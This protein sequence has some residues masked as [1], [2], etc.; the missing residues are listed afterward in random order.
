MFLDYILDSMSSDNKIIKITV[1]ET[2]GEFT[3]GKVSDEETIKAIREKIEE[4]EM[5]SNFDYGDGNYFDASSF[6][7]FFGVYG[8]HIPG[9]KVLIEESLDGKKFNEIYDGPIE[10]TDI[11][12]FLS[13]NPTPD[14]LISNEQLLIFTYKYE[15]RIHCTFQ[16]NVPINNEFDLKD[17]Y[18]GYML[19]DETIF[20]EDE[21]LEHILY[22]PKNEMESYIKEVNKKFDA[23]YEYDD[24]DGLEE[25]LR[26]EFEGKSEIAK[27]IIEKHSIN[28]DY[29]E[30]KGEWENDYIKVVDSSD[31]ILFED[32]Q[33]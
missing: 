5:S 32:G 12:L 6:N 30:G 18:L 7:D 33:W 31:E 29:C 19:M 25:L 22:I 14:N 17:I 13:S 8:P 28:Y 1:I 3:V 16:I 4:G 26:D 21:I 9:S 20:T 23:D 10:D 27:K 2:G 24:Y 11:R 15:K